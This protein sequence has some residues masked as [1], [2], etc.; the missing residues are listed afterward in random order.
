MRKSRRKRKRPKCSYAY[1]NWKTDGSLLNLRAIRKSTTICFPIMEIRWAHE[2]EVFTWGP[3]RTDGRSVGRALW[4]QWLQYGISRGCD[5]FPPVLGGITTAALWYQCLCPFAGWVNQSCAL[6]C[7]VRF[8]VAAFD[9]SGVRVWLYYHILQHSGSFIFKM[10]A[11]N[12]NGGG[13]RRQV[14]SSVDFYRRVPKD[15]TEA[16]AWEICNG[17]TCISAFLAQSL[18]PF[19]LFSNIFLFLY[20]FPF[21]L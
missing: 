13:G 15:L 20:I 21:F 6:P 10:H 3:R 5:P 8:G 12:L 17:L 18:F 2:V 9:N 11:N 1:C 14:L 19:F 4:Q 16:S 7:L